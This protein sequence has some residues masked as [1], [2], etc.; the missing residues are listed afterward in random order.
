VS[1]SPAERLTITFVC[2]WFPPEPAALPLS[3]VTGLA[4]RGHG[5]QVITGIPN[6]PDG[7]VKAGYRAWRPVR[8][9][10]SDITVWRTPL[11]PSHSR[12]VVGRIANYLSW[13]MTS[14]IA[15]FLLVRR[16]DVVLVY[17]SPATAAIGPFAWSLLRRT[18]YVLLIEDMWPDSVTASG[19][20]ARRGS[21]QVVDVLHAMMRRLYRNAGHIAVTSPGMA[22]LIA[23]RGAEKSKT[24]V[25]YNWAPDE[26]RQTLDRLQARDRLGVP[27]DCFL[28]T[29][30]GN[31]G[32]MQDLG[33]T[34]E[35]VHRCG[36]DVTLLLVGDGVE[37]KRLRQLARNSDNV[38]FHPPVT[39]EGM[40]GIHAATDVHLVSLAPRPIFASTIPSKV[41]SILA[42]GKPVIVAVDGDAA[43]V[44]AESGAGWVVP[45]GDAQRLATTVTSAQRLPRGELAAMGERGQRFYS[46]RMS[47]QVGV[48]RLERILADA[49]ETER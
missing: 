36:A 7:K 12:S 25:V 35:G 39:S 4:A 43:A 42:A 3:I 40:P 28:V 21:H 44:V 48:T 29:Y 23:E 41:Q 38:V 47:Q 33:F 17:S 19:M 31:L 11:V 16:S 22:D 18:P 32:V 26:R 6:Y 15:G 30:A 24:S 13:A 2:Q 10:I 5:V 27:R 37:L 46:T 14:M 34:V 1:A 45:H 49:A 9:S 8:E 20:L